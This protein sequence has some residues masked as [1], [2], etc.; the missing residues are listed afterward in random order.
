ML[1]APRP[2]QRRGELLTDE[3]Y[4]RVLEILSTDPDREFTKGEIVEYASS[5]NIELSDDVWR[6][7]ANR[8]KDDDRIAITG[9]AKATRYRFRAAAGF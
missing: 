9:R 6:A 4:E 8:M 7:I 5:L 2:R 3:E 1:D